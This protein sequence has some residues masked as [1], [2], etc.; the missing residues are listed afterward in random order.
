MAALAGAAAGGPAGSDGDSCGTD[1]V[2]CAET[3]FGPV[4]GGTADCARPVCASLRAITT[5]AVRK[6]SA[7]NL[8]EAH[9]NDMAGS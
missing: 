8:R 4:G 5:A 3:E 6:H 2:G 7:L 9:P 1:C